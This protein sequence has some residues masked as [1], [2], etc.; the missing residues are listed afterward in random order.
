MAIP[1]S[2]TVMHHTGEVAESIA[3]G[4]NAEDFPFLADILNGLYSDVIAAPVRE[5]STNA[6]DSHVQAGNP[7]PIEITLPS[8][9]RLE[10]IVQDH[11]IGMSIDDLRLTY[12]RYGRS[13][14]RESNDVAGMLGLGS[15]SPLSYAVGFTVTAVKNHEKVSAFVTKNK[16]GLGV[17]Q[18]L[19]PPA[20]TD[21][22]NGVQV[23]IPVDRYDVDDFRRAANDLFRFWEPGSVLIDGEPPASQDW[24]TSALHIDADTWLVRMDAGLHSSYVVTGN[25]PYPVAD[26]TVGRMTY[27]F[28]ARLNI[29]DVVPVPSREALK[30]TPWTDETLSDLNEYITLRFRH[31]LNAAKESTKTRWEETLLRS[32]WMGSKTTLRASQERPIWVYDPNAWRRKASAHTSYQIANITLSNVVVVTG[33]T[34]KNLS[35]S[36]RERLTDFAGHSA[37]F[38]ILPQ[39]IGVGMLDGRPN[40]FTWDRIVGSTEKPKAARSARGPKVETVY[41]I[42]GKG[43]MTAAELVECDDTLLYLNPGEHPTHGRLAGATIVCLYSSAQLPRIKRFVPHISPYQDEVARQR[44]AAQAAIT[45]ADLDIM[46]ARTLPY[47]FA[48]FS[49]DEVKDPELAS[50]IRAN[51][52]D[53]TPTIA[54]A[55]HF[56]CSFDFKPIPKF[57]KRYPLVVTSM[58]YGHAISEANVKAERLFYMNARYEARQA[59]K[60]VV[61]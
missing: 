36:A 29:G 19:V 18:I 6:W 43:G 51:G 4:I 22:P 38:V 52:L 14:K 31:A 27:R 30:H 13:D 7:R 20:A 23:K 1:H 15:K 5:M 54:N 33:F 41:N 37:T 60:Q 24:Q 28:V 35:P 3:M 42:Y 25:V 58:P 39:G 47:Q 57:D 46:R 2:A 56:G 50:L 12:S 49:A 10:F 32:V 8:A 21:E 9:E 55:K 59:S 48:D 34:A 11:G 44:K 53:D 61:S 45:P 40:T 17:I 16:E 26:V